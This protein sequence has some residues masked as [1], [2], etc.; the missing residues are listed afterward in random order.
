MRETAAIQ[1]ALN[2]VA[3]PALSRRAMDQ[4]LPSGLTFLLEVAAGDTEA[5][6]EAHRIT[7]RSEAELQHAAGFF[8]E[9]GLLSQDVTNSYRVLGAASED[10]Q[11]TLR[12][13][14]VL[15]MKWLHPD[16]A[17]RH[18]SAGEV[19]RSVFAHRV[20]AAWDDVKT[21][22]RRS[23]YDRRVALQ[24][25]RGAAAR[26]GEAA[27][28]LGSRRRQSGPKKKDKVSGMRPKR[29][30]ARPRRRSMGSEPLLV[31]IV[32]ALWRHG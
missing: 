30:V 24:G 19:D 2:L 1:A 11:E 29:S 28:R 20:N 23:A 4:P 32:R 13:H 22:E 15:L 9:Q 27:I 6:A 17:E 5:L 12:R 14:M 18:R 25:D 31:R 8:I 16:I 26:V 3:R 21:R 10:A 7:E